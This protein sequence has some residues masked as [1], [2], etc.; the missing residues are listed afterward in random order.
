MDL[1][2]R[3]KLAGGSLLAL[4]DPDGPLPFYPSVH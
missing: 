1:R 4:L 3:L 2:H